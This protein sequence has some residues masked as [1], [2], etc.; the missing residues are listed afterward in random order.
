[1]SL[2]SFPGKKK[3]GNSN[4]NGGKFESGVIW[5]IKTMAAEGRG[6]TA[7]ELQSRSGHWGAEN[8]VLKLFLTFVLIF[9][10][11]SIHV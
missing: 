2:F 3:A 4:E 11:V 6:S 7:E 8:F 10:F 5:Q 9:L 1:L